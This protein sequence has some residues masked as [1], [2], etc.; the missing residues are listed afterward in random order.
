MTQ[1]PQV[2][3][4]VVMMHVDYGLIA[5]M[6]EMV[7]LFAVVQGNIQIQMIQKDIVKV[8]AVQIFYVVIGINY[9]QVHV[10][11]VNHLM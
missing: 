4:N 11:L 9:L 10:P 2:L 7:K 6:K 8:N 3:K 5:S 1:S